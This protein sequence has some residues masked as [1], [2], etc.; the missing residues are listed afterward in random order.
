MSDEKTIKNNGKE[1]RRVGDSEFIQEGDMRM[2]SVA[3]GELFDAYENDVGCKRIGGHG[4]WREIEGEAMS[5]NKSEMVEITYKVSEKYANAVAD[6]VFDGEY[7]YAADVV[8]E[9]AA[10]IAA[11]EARKSEYERWR[12][13][14]CAPWRL[15]EDGQEVMVT[16]PDH[17][18]ES[19]D[20]ACVW[21]NNPELMR[22]IAAA[23]RLLDALID[24]R[25]YI[26][27]AVDEEQHQVV[28]LCSIEDVIRVAVGNVVA[29]KVFGG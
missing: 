29:A 7:E 9:K 28:M 2:G 12:G 10:C 23:P 24:A 18:R 14:V 17:V 1:Y 20:S 13:K 6:G 11:L 19:I 8:A 16:C 25:E 21:N 15:S 5:E 3:S 26:L 22:L 4:H 27:E